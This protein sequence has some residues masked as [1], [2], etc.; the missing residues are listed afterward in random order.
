M[1]FVRRTARPHGRPA[2]RE[3]TGTAGPS[4]KTSIRFNSGLTGPENSGQGDPGGCV[5][6]VSDSAAHTA[7]E[8][9]PCGMNKVSAVRMNL[10]PPTPRLW[11]RRNGGWNS[12]REERAAILAPNIPAP[13]WSMAKDRGAADGLAVAVETA[14]VIKPQN[15]VCAADSATMSSIACNGFTRGL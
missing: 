7:V 9:L 12:G 5:H 6:P 10:G 3:K 4:C 2:F 14:T 11:R 13:H 8:W 1:P 15:A